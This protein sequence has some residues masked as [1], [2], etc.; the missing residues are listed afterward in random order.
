[1]GTATRAPQP[2]PSHGA[3]SSSSTSHHTRGPQARQ[4]HRRPRS[5]WHSCA[6]ARPGSSGSAQ[7]QRQ[8]PLSGS[9][10]SSVSSPARHA[11]PLSA[12][13]TRK[14]WMKA[15]HPP[16]GCAGHPLPAW[17]RADVGAAWGRRMPRAMM[18]TK[19]RREIRSH[20]CS[21][22]TRAG[23]TTSRRL[24]SPCCERSESEGP[25]GSGMVCCGLVCCRPFKF[26]SA[27]REP[28][29]SEA[30]AAGTS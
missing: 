16:R 25:R 26:A 13:C 30:E 12:S 2:L 18:T 4:C 10:P 27:R 21:S 19:H 6:G 14:A 22:T 5:C 23:R 20:G 28:V 15:A 8:T 7:A 11:R 1:M 9:R 3:T 24:V 17:G 29:S